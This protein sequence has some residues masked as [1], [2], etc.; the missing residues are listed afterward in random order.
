[1]AK[2]HAALIAFIATL[3]S[4]SFDIHVTPKAAADKIILRKKENSATEI[5][6][7]VTTAPEN[8]KANKAVIQAL[9]KAL[10]IS[11]SAIEIVRGETT[12]TKTIK[13]S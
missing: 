2:T 4:D 9:S 8:G 5:R 13:I 11:K 3:E 10:G 12:R 1:M 7:Y 6:L